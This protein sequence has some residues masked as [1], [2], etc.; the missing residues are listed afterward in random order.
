MSTS[1]RMLLGAV[2]AGAIGALLTGCG[3][4]D[5][6]PSGAVKASEDLY[7]GDLDLTTLDEGTGRHLEVPGV[8]YQVLRRGLVEAIPR[9]MAWEL[10]FLE[11]PED[12]D[13][14]DELVR[15]AE[16]E[17]VL[18]AEIAVAWPLLLT[19]APA[20]DAGS[21][22]TERLV[23]SGQERDP[24]AAP[25]EQGRTVRVVA[26]VPADPDPEALELEVLTGA[27]RQ[28]LSLVDGSRTASDVEHVYTSWVRARAEHRFW[29][30]TLEG[31]GSRP[32]VAGAVRTVLA[33]PVLDG[34]VWPAL[35]THLLGVGLSALAPPHGVQDAGRLT[36]LLPDGAE[37]AP[38][39]EAGRAYR[40]ATEP[41][42][43]VW[44]EVPVEAEAVTLHLE[45]AVEREDGGTEELGTEEIAV[46]LETVPRLDAG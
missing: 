15:P 10:G 25:I 20:E 6:L 11:R 5:L 13:G 32:V 1:R 36:V 41:S 17:V 38:V 4:G 31:H 22:R 34:G 46:T 40:D 2:G 19:V 16:G 29:S 27:V 37:A 9:S 23:L 45:L 28:R 21:A 24:W 35:G 42:G 33:R 44:F 14:G 43:V 12:A 39:G 30:R 7:L 8:R 18:A 26:V 3:D